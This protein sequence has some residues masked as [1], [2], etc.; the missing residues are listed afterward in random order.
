VLNRKRVQRWF[1]VGTLLLADMISICLG[2][3]IA[4][5]VRFQTK[6]GLFYEHEHSPVDLY[7]KLTLAILPLFLVVLACYHLYSERR[8]FDGAT[9]YPRI[10]SAVTMAVMI[11]ILLSFLAESTL[12]IAR[13]WIVLAWIAAIVTVSFGRFVVRRMTHRL[14]SAGHLVQ[15][16][17]I[18]GSGAD[19]VDLAERIDDTRDSG[20]QIAGIV[21]CSVF[22]GDGVEADARVPVVALIAAH[23]ADALLISAASVSQ[24]VLSRIV[25]EVSRLPTALHVVPGMHEIL[26]T[27]V[28]A[29]EIRGLPIVTMNKVRITGLDLLLKRL[30]DYSVAAAVLLITSPLL[31]TIA[32]LIRLTSSG[33]VL[34]R[35]RV[36][37]QQ[38][39]VFDAWK[40][41]TMKVDGDE[42]LRSRP[43]LMEELQRSGK[44]TDDPRVTR[45]GSML[46]RWSIDELPQLLNVLRGQMSLVGPRMIT[47]PELTHFGRWRENVSTVKPGLTGLWQVS[48]RSDLGYEDRV[49]LD[50]HYIRS[51]S[52]WIDIEILLRTIPAVIHGRGAY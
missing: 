12:V 18:V 45:I 20:L 15:R 47:E 11:I 14:H 16:V 25:R 23:R 24:P 39:R 34:Y 5:L 3:G 4:Y 44:L 38:G 46:R 6:W 17:L 28:Q 27:G 29:G 35:R 32:L 2:F 50:M 40:F 36:I 8:I 10:I 1:S 52:I 33:P 13:G 19:V 41:R 37:G 26:T 43:A 48:G 21:D 7:V 49:R 9:E 42:I 31:I 51:Y 30:L 22:E